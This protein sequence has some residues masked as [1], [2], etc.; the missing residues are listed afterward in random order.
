MRT[1]VGNLDVDKLKTV[2]PHLSKLSN[3][4]DNVV[5]KNWVCCKICKLVTKVNAIDTEIPSISGLATKT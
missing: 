3:A 4:V 2:H 1:T 5:N